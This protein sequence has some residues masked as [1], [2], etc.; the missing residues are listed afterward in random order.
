MEY[1]EYHASPHSVRRRLEVRCMAD[2]HWYA[3]SQCANLQCN[4]FLKVSFEDQP[5]Q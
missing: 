1:L 3:C 5:Q 4:P 2:V